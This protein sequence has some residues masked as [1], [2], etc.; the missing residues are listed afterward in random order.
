MWPKKHQTCILAAQAIS[1]CKK[2][3]SETDFLDDV[4]MIVCVKGKYLQLE[5]RLLPLLS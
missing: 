4:V 3:A 1:S 2:L 5:V